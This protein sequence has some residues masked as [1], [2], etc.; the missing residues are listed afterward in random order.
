VNVGGVVGVVKF[1]WAEAGTRSAL[2]VIADIHRERQK[3]IGRLLLF[4]FDI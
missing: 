4:N 2:S 3:V 1:D